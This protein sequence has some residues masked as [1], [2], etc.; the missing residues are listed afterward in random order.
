MHATA[1][2]PDYNEM[3]S[4]GRAQAAQV[5]ICSVRTGPRPIEAGFTS[6]GNHRC[7]E[8]RRIAGLR[9]HVVATTR[10]AERTRRKHGMQR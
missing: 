10:S 7:V 5:A 9:P 8:Q 6:P 2:V 1:I 3:A 4:R